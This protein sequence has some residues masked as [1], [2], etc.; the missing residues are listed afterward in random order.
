MRVLIVK[1]SSL[2]DIIHTLPAIT[3]ARRARPDIV[4]DWVVEENFVEV[5]SWHPA[6]DRVIPVA[7]R[8]WRK[9]PF[10]SLGGIE[11]KKFKDDIKREHYDLVIDAQG[12]IKS[13]IISRLSRGLTVG[14]SDSTVREPLA[15]L[16]YN[17]VYSVPKTEHAVDRVRQLFSRALQYEYNPRTIDYGVSHEAIAALTAPVAKATGSTE[18]AKQVVFLHGTTWATKHWPVDY[19][20]TLAQ[21]AASAGFE[22]LLPWGDEAERARAEHIAKAAGATVLPKLTLS[23]LAAQLARARGVIAV[24]TG[25]GHLAAALARPTLSLYGPTDPA[26]SGTYGVSQKHLCS[27]FACAP[28]L[29]KTCAYKGPV[30]LEDGKA[31]APPCFSTHP[32]ASVW[33]TFEALLAKAALGRSK[34]F[35][36]TNG[37]NTGSYDTNGY[38]TNDNGSIG[39]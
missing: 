2:G 38:G 36:D 12:L 21:H 11:F 19:W 33:Q 7:F 5:P 29:Q 8:R 14:L 39:K 31:V 32:P 9:K 37:Y 26:L 10:R 27:T 34:S 30:V 6:V 4:F 15:T 23:G 28:C 24:D 16:F 35:Y 25:L 17:K 20:C 18:D 22:V 13:G 1:V 3:D